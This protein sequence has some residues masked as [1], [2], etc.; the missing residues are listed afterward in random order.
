MTLDGTELL[1]MPAWSGPGRGLF[2]AC[3]VPDRGSRGQPHRPAHRSEEGDLPPAGKAFGSPDVTCGI[4]EEAT[5]R[6]RRWV[7]I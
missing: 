7:S 4:R 2:L 5:P 6:R 3:A 1:G